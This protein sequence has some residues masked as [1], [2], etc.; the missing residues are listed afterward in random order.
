VIQSDI[1][2]NG[3][4]ALL[5]EVRLDDFSTAIEYT[6]EQAAGAVSVLVA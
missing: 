6:R 1:G 5:R 4:L 3:D 2:V